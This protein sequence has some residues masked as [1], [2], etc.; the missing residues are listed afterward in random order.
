[1]KNVRIIAALVA[2]VAVVS[3]LSAAVFAED[4]ALDVAAAPEAVEEVA[5]TEE[6]GLSETAIKA[7]VAGAVIL[8]GAGVGAVCM[9]LSVTKSVDGSAR[10]PEA[11]SNI[12]TT[13]M[14]GLVFIETAII[15]A[16]IIAIL[17]IFVL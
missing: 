4:E 16:L 9:A 7:I 17:I 1:M 10:Q 11:A 3:V 8:V 5:E 2:L 12:R 13:M 14:M 6:G 15:Y